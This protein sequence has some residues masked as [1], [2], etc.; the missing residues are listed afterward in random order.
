MDIVF[1]D[2]EISGFRAYDQVI[3]ISVL[4]NRGD[5]I[6]S[7]LVSGS[8]GITDEIHNLTGLTVSQVNS[9][10]DKLSKL[11]NTAQL[12]KRDT[13]LVSY[14]LQFDI[15]WINHTLMFEDLNLG[16]IRGICLLEVVTRLKGYK[17][18]LDSA[19]EEFIPE[20]GNE[21]RNITQE[22]GSK[23][24][25]SL[26]DSKMHYKLYESLASKYPNDVRS[27]LRDF[28]PLDI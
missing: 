19:F 10:G 25:R 22:T 4:N 11:T 18:S 2:V 1:L 16:N 26:F 20:K 9:M 6:I 17:V 24:H 5:V 28:T 8:E 12:S 14:G 27:C 3:D 7:S 21:L 23:R 15:N 13:L